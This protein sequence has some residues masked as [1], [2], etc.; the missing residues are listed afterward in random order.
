VAGDL[1]SHFSIR[2]LSF[3]S[4]F[5]ITTKTKKSTLF[6]FLE[7]NIS[8]PSVYSSL[9]STL[10]NLEPPKVPKVSW[11]WQNQGVDKGKN[12]GVVRSLCFADE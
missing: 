2:D 5:P 10:G 3:C 8:R 12:S 1:K 11:S 7:I 4:S 9:S 6:L